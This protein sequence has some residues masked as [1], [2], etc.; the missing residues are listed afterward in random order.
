M[1]LKRNL[2]SLGQLDRSRLCYKADNG[3]IKFSKGSLIAI[4]EE[5][6]NGLYEVV[7]ETDM[8]T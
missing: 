6:K 2:I 8:K 7:I 1:D 3:I 5:M 4:K